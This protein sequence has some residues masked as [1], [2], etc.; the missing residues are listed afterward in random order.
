M[1]TNLIDNDA[2]PHWQR[3]GVCAAVS[4]VLGLASPL[5]VRAQETSAIAPRAAPATAG[6]SDV[7]RSRAGM[8]VPED[9]PPAPLTRNPA[10]QEDARF[11]WKEFSKLTFR[12]WPTP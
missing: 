2:T 7:A 4:A 12:R 11:F 5:S 6:P 1:K 9:S 8:S 10:W 3:L